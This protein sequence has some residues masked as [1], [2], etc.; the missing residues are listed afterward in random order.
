MPG[1]QKLATQIHARRAAC[2]W[3]PWP[4][5]G[6]SRCRT[7]ATA[8]A[9]RCCGCEREVLLVLNWEYYHC[10]EQGN[11]LLVLYL[12][13]FINVNQGRI[14]NTPGTCYVYQDVKCVSPAHLLSLTYLDSG[15]GSHIYKT[16]NMLTTPYTLTRCFP[17]A[18]QA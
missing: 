7:F 5:V 18:G 17:Y 3:T 8:A 15:P 9:R 2:C 10:Y 12:T 1:K 4:R 13:P 6:H 11:T 16:S 14:Y